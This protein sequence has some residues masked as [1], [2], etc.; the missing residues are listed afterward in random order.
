MHIFPAIISKLQH[1]VTLER[2]LQDW[3]FQ[4][5]HRTIDSNSGCLEASIRMVYCA[6]FDANSSKNKVTCSW[7]KFP[8]EPMKHSWLFPL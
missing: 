2:V 4:M 7:L 1:D 6:T 5:I 3:D 8:M